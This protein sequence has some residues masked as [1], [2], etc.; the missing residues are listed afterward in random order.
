M[1]DVHWIFDNRINKEIN[2]LIKAGYGVYYI[3]PADEEE[4]KKYK[5][6]HPQVHVISI[7]KYENRRE[8]MRKGVREAYRAALSTNADIYHFHD[9][10]L[11]KAGIWLKLRGKKVIYDVHEDYRSTIIS[12]RRGIFKYVLRSGYAFF[13]KIAN[14]LFDGIVVVSPAIKKYF[15]S[16]KTIILPNYP[17]LSI[18]EKLNKGNDESEKTI[19]LY[20]GGI[21]IQRGIKEMIEASEKASK[22]CNLKLVIIGKAI[23]EESKKYLGLKKEYFVYIEQ[24]PYEE[25][26]KIASSADVGMI[27][28]H[29]TRNHLNSS[30]VKLFE[31]MALGIPIIA[32][33]FPKWHEYMDQSQCA[34]YVDPRN[35]LEISKAMITLCKDQELR[36]EMGNRGKK[37]AFEKYNWEKIE[38]R[39]LNLYN[40]VL[41]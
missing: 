19:F 21:S 9:P 11:I 15:S 4:V 10:E 17:D 2:T 34:F 30:P 20:L 12:R 39:L 6:S 33:D 40:R 41:K 29:P 24:L 37:T 7:H 3:V 31:Y 22:E 13:E 23:D 5:N 28:L 8:R 38:G 35:P 36:N 16:K 18:F 26:L 1:T 27:V 32:S 25:A 14:L